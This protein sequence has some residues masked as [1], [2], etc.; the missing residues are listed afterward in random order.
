M[1]RIKTICQFLWP[2]RPYLRQQNVTRKTLCLQ[3]Q[4]K[5][6]DQAPQPHKEQKK[7]YMLHFG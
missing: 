5:E 7:L 4:I 2:I 6:Q 3:Q 1:T